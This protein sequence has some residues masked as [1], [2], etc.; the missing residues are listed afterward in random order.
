MLYYGKIGGMN[1]SEQ[2]IKYE[3]TKIQNEIL[4]LEEKYMH[5]IERIVTSPVFLSDLKHIEEETQEINFDYNSP[6]IDALG[7]IQLIIDMDL[8][9]NEYKLEK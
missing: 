3:R 5:I 8:K 2:N 7:K 1:M 4:D 6:V 9:E